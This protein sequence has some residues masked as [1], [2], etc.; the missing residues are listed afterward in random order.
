MNDGIK[1]GLA[2]LALAALVIIGLRVAGPGAVGTGED[3]AT[4]S[5]LAGGL[6]SLLVVAGVVLL[7]RGLVVLVRRK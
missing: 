6:A 5:S 2:V 7:A 4:T 1:Q 3:A